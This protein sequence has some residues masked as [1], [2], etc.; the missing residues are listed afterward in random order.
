MFVAFEW[1]DASW[2]TTQ[3]DKL[4]NY[5][6]EKWFSYDYYDFPQYNKKSSF[7]VNEYLQWNFWN[8]DSVTSKQASL[9][10]AVDRFYEK[11]NIHNSIKTKDFVISNRYTSS[12]IFHQSVKINDIEKEKDFIS[13][14]EDLEYNILWLP[15]PDK[16]IFFDMHI[17]ISW[18]L[19]KKRWSWEWRDIHE[20]DYNYLSKSYYKAIEVAEK[21]WWHIIKCYEWKNPRYIEDI[22]EDVK[23]ACIN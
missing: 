6:E 16:V 21:M 5:L 22:F 4:I 2:K 23:I 9:L 17:D 8:I 14:L 19:N 10:Y 3:F 7:L 18:K 11:N 1:V 15:K 13:W 12:N 20:K